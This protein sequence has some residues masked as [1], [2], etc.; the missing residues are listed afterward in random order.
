MQ[1]QDE[2]SK[3]QFIDSIGFLTY[4]MAISGITSIRKYEEVYGVC[5]KEN[6]LLQNNEMV[7][8]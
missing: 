2:K 6:M 3:G 7:M 5:E 4:G 8:R 1:L